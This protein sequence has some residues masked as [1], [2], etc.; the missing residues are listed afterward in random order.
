MPV[1]R[2]S[3]CAFGGAN[4]TDLYITTISEGLSEDEKTQQPLAGDL[5]V[6]RMDVAGFPEAVFSGWFRPI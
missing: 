4:F 1:S 6:V 5:F 3:S 2:P